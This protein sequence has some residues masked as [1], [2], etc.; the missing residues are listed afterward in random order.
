LF[1][2]III[3]KVESIKAC[4]IEVLNFQFTLL[5]LVE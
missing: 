2:V 4:G 1:L 5:F 3:A